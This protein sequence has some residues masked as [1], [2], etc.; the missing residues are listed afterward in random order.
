MSVFKRVA[1]LGLAIGVGNQILRTRKVEFC[2]ENPIEFLGL[3]GEAAKSPLNTV[4]LHP[5]ALSYLRQ[6]NDK[7]KEM[8]GAQFQEIPLN[9]AVRTAKKQ[10]YLHVAW[11]WNEFFGGKVPKI[12]PADLP[13]NSVHQFGVAIDV[14]LKEDSSRIKR[15]LKTAKWKDTKSHE[16]H[17]F[18]ATSISDFKSYV[19]GKQDLVEEDRTAYSDSI[20]EFF[21]TRK[22]V[23]RDWPKFL[24][25]KR[26]AEPLLRQIDILEARIPRLQHRVRTARDRVRQLETAL[27]R[28]RQ[29]QAAAER[30]YNSF[31][32][33]Y[34][35][36]GAS[37]ND[38]DHPDLKRRFLR[39]KQTLADRVASLRNE[40]RRLESELVRL[41]AAEQDAIAD[42]N[43]VQGQIDI[44]KARLEAN[45]KMYFEMEREMASRCETMKRAANNLN[46]AIV[47][48]ENKLRSS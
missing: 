5:E 2:G 26:K 41:R 8:S 12:Y 48:I 14:D 13:G 24:E 18:E 28:A 35:P 39:E 36:N 25:E 1:L 43:A 38:C 23:E 45:H 20:T 15:A 44:L 46:S 19:K 7:Y 34:C 10:A 21:E 16:P 17:H 9:S 22:I 29:R 3:E 11:T 31:R 47:R 42:L 33:T 32:Y 37:Y 4:A 40:A 27:S 30:Q 6:A